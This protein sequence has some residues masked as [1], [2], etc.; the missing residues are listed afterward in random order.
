MA[1]SITQHSTVQSSAGHG[2]ATHCNCNSDCS[3]SPPLSVATPYGWRTC[4][5]AISYGIPFTASHCQVDAAVVTV[6]GRV[7]AA[8][9]VRVTQR[10]YIQSSPAG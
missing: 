1:H 10:R 5:H 2:S 4:R 3:F 8:H 7:T 6:C 9:T